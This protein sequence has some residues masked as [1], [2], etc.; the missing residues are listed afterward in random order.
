MINLEGLFYGNLENTKGY[1][2]DEI[3][4]EK[5]RGARP[6]EKMKWPTG[7]YTGQNFGGKGGTRTALLLFRG[8]F[9]TGN[10]RKR[11]QEKV[12]EV[13]KTILSTVVYQ[14]LDGTRKCSGK[15]QRNPVC[16]VET[17]HGS[18][19]KDERR[20]T[21]TRH[22]TRQ[23]QGFVWGRGGKTQYHRLTTD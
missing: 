15:S 16:R 17:L 20:D 1:K 8:T 6:R 21:T 12:A 13:T 23:S 18:R 9:F 7:L 22:R 5:S 2:I 4:P 3:G 11:H 10:T 19:I 14:T